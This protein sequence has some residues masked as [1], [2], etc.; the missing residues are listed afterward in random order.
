M[1]D[2]TSDQQN[3]G[4]TATLTIDRD[5]AARF[6]IQPQQIDERSTTRSASARWCSIFTQV[7]AYWVV[8]GVP[9][10]LEGNPNTLRML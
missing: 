3:A 7:N 9:R 1:R 2:V 6:G 4:T 10:D 8:M 5:A